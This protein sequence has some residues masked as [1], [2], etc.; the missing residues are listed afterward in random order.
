MINIRI[1]KNRVGNMSILD[2]T[3]KIEVSNVE[4]IHLKRAFV[5]NEKGCWHAAKSKRF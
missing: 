4:F 3:G 1:F 5:K 2:I